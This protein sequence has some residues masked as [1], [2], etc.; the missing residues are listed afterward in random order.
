MALPA[1]VA[2]AGRRIRARRCRLRGVR[3][4]LRGG[5][6]VYGDAVCGV[7]ETLTSDAGV[8]VAGVAERLTSDAGV[9]VAGV[10]CMFTRKFLFSLLGGNANL[11]RWRLRS[12][13]VCFIYQLCLQFN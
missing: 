3:R 13:T 8:C 10:V 4:R 9:C 6:Y 2:F 1:E 7:A 11:A 12:R 5:V